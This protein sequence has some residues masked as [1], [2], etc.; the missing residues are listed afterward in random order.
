MTLEKPTRFC[1]AQSRIEAVS[2]PD[3]D[4][5]ASCPCV[6]RSPAELAFSCSIG[7]WKPWLLGPSSHMPCC[8]ATRCISAAL[9]CGMPA[10]STVAAFTL[11]RPASSSAG[12]ISSSGRAMMARSA[13]ACARS[14]S[15]PV[16]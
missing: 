3:C 7:R 10:D 5:S 15:V 9:A 2:A 8:L 16:V 4:T 12:M 6:A 14:A 11:M 13:R 1:R